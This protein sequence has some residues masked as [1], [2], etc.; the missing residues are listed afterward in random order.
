MV[1]DLP[2]QL[3]TG[4]ILINFKDSIFVVRWLKQQRKVQDGKEMPSTPSPK[5]TTIISVL[6][7]LPISVCSPPPEDFFFF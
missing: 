6:G 2:T 4:D 1:Q 3:A 5:G 7:L